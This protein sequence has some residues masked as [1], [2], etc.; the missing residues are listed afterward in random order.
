MRTSKPKIVPRTKVVFYQEDETA[1]VL[2][3]LGALPRKARA[4]CQVYL[5]HL[6]ELGHE[7]KR[8][9]A[10]YLRDGIHEL[11]PSYQGVPYRL[12]YFF[13]GPG[14]GKAAEETRIVVVSHGLVKE[15]AV[16]DA[17]IDPAIERK[18]RF[19]AHPER[20]TFNPGLKR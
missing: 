18:R 6:E 17:E 3:W 10:A 5:L 19:E 11:R 9:V 7:L 20:H 14:K 15:Q 8:P 2:K 1:L 4:K 16:P 12:L 13:A